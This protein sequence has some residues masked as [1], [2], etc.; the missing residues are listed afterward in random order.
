[1]IKHANSDHSLGLH[2]V[3]GCLALLAAIPC[4]AGAQEDDADKVL[5]K[6]RWREG[7]FGVSLRPPLGTLLQTRNIDDAV[8][9]ITKDN[10]YTITVFLKTLAPNQEMTI[11]QVVDSAID[12]F[13]FAQPTAT[14]DHQRVAKP[15]GRPGWIVYFGVNLP[16]KSEKPDAGKN[17]PVVVEAMLKAARVQFETAERMRVKEGRDI[18]AFRLYKAIAANS[19]DKAI[20]KKA[21]EWVASYEVDNGFM[22]R[23]LQDDVA[24]RRRNPLDVDLKAWYMGQAIM[25]LA[26]NAFVI[27]QLEVGKDSY[28]AVKPIFEAVVKSMEVQ[29]PEELDKQRKELIKAGEV[30]DGMLNHKRLLEAMLPPVIVPIVDDKGQ[31]AGE[32]PLRLQYMRVMEEGKDVGWM[33][34]VHRERRDNIRMLDWEEVK[35]LKTGKTKRVRKSVPGEGVNGIGVDVYLRIHFGPRAVDSHTQTFLSES[36]TFESWSIRTTVRDR[37]DADPNDKKGKSVPLPVKQP[38]KPKVGPD[39]KVIPPPPTYHVRTWLETGVQNQEQITII[40]EGPTGIDRVN[41]RRPAGYITQTE[42]YLLAPLLPHKNAEYGF[43]AYYPNT[44]NIA[45]RTLK[46]VP[47]GGE[48]GGFRTYS[49]PALDAAE[50]VTKYDSRGSI[51]HRTLGEGRD[52]IPTTREELARIWNVELPDDTAAPATPEEDKPLPPTKGRIPR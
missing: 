45:F 39:G 4:R 23:F 8:V 52:V 10:T 15:A 29:N 35:D 3:L 22:A 31:P 51:L 32:K 34:T 47:N 42:L 1:M 27:V 26:P 19:P 16:L 48:D 24:R 6:E 7:S 36:G 28:E 30:L 11:K 25:Q 50:Q 21:K 5:A 2:V 44:G 40:R 38:E 14:I 13:G 20:A 41:W 46:V 12:Q 43:Y 17:D 18:A 49:R 37:V 9:R 33:K